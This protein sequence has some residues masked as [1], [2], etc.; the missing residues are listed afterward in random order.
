MLS[1]SRSEV[2][3]Y[4]GIGLKLN[5][6]LL[7]FFIA[8]S[9]L[10]VLFIS[11]YNTSKDKLLDAGEE[12]SREIIKYTMGIL[13]SYDQMVKEGKM[14]LDVAQEKAKTTLLGPMKSDGTRDLLQSIVC[15]TP[16]VYVYAI[17]KSADVLMHPFLEGA[18]INGYISADGQDLGVLL[19]DETKFD[20]VVE[21]LFEN[22][23]TG[24]TGIAYDYREYFEPW[25]WILAYG[26]SAEFI[27]INPLRDM[28][29]T[30][31][32]VGAITM[33]IV[34]LAVFFLTSGITGPIKELSK[35]IDRLSSYDLT[36]DEDSKSTKFL[37]RKD[38]IGSITRSLATMQKNLINLTKEITD[39]SQQVAAASEELTAYSRQS[40]SSA[41]E[42]ARTIDEIARGASDQA[43]NTEDG[44]ICINELGQLI[45]KDQKYIEDLNY[46]A[47]E[48]NTLK[49]EGLQGLKELVEKTELSSTASKNIHDIIINTNE[50]AKK[51]E[52]AS[53]MIKSIA[54]QTNLL[55]LNAAIEAARA[56]ETGRGFAVVAEEIRRLSEQSNSFTGE[57]S[58]IIGELTGKTQ[59]AVE[60]IQ[61]VAKLILSQA[62]SVEESNAKFEGIAASIERMKR[63]IE[64]I[65]QSG[66]E[67]QNKKQQIIGIIENLSA[68]SEENAAGT[69]EASASIEEQTSSMEEI[70]NSSE[71]L[72]KM[73]EEMQK[74][75]CKF[76]Y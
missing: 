62:E 74:S 54:E 16:D 37:K 72:A 45:E 43:K 47:N 17:D 9:P 36:F 7:C 65:N 12:K 61:E 68:I 35:V 73:A 28:I 51:I 4:K 48:V 60:T 57:I 11:S 67:M 14:S 66:L 27:Y 41:E 6:F 15:A 70:A 19:T 49:D 64:D 75:I 34:L 53:Q 2:S 39:T 42:V 50:S 31:V 56:G 33:L 32:F 8:I 69:Q 26:S 44:S 21:Y 30:Y 46:A 20:K 58:E 5:V 18:S 40:T 59:Y 76:K 52:N 1:K 63:V 25:G 71:V 24:E 13:S 38:E 3:G 55:A 22:D 10:I 29:N 23:M